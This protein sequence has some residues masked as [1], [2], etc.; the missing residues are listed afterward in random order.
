MARI[1]EDNFLEVVKRNLEARVKHVLKDEL[2]KRATDQFKRLIRKEID[3][4]V[5][6]LCFKGIES[7]ADAASLRNELH[8]FLHRE[9]ASTIERKIK[10]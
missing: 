4:L 10:P 7:F 6:E 5:D 1:N 3:T 9:D 8:V 2:E